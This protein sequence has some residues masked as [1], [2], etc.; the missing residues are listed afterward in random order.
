M[1][2]N[3]LKTRFL[4]FS[5][6]S[7]TT[8]IVKHGSHKAIKSSSLNYDVF[9]RC[10]RV[11]FFAFNKIWLA[12]TESRKYDIHMRLHSFTNSL[13]EKWETLYDDWRYSSK[14][15]LRCLSLRGHSSR[16]HFRYLS[17][18][19]FTLSYKHDKLSEVLCSDN[20]PSNH[21]I[22]VQKF[23][24]FTWKFILW[25]EKGAQTRFLH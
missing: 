16:K 19:T 14:I 8:F 7:K 3:L 21:S 13:L 17:I 15:Y 1:H 4:S 2:S 5:F 12:E 24:H 22:L 23:C 25:T 10:W 6:P 9:H 18:E 11:A 20:I